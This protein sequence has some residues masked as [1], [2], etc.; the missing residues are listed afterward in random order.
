M[1]SKYK[2]KVQ[3]INLIQTLGYALSLSVF[4]HFSF[5]TN[6]TLEQCRVEFTIVDENREGIAGALVEIKEVNQ[7][8]IS[9]DGGRAI[10]L[11]DQNSTYTL[12]VHSLGFET[13]LKAIKIPG[14]KEFQLQV[15]LSESTTELSEVVVQGQTEEER[16]L[17]QPYKA[18]FISME[19][20]RS[21][22]VEVVNIINQMPGMRI[23][24]NGGA[25][26]DVDISINGI[27]GKGVKIFID[28]IPVYLLGA[29]YSFNN[30]S[31]GIIENIE[32][33]K[34]TIPV[35]FG[36]DALGGVINITTRQK[37]SDY[38]DVSYSYGSWNTHQSTLS[39][40]KR[41]G[42]DRK[43]S[44]GI[45]G[46]QTYS[47]NDYWMDDVLVWDESAT[48]QL[49]TTERGRARRFNDT[50]DSKLGR[51]NLGVR[52]LSWADEIVLF[53]SLSRVN[54]EWQHDIIPNNPWGEPSSEEDSWSSA[55]T[56]R[57]TSNDGRLS[58]NITGGYLEN[59][60]DFLDTARRTYYWDGNFIPKPAGA[61]ESGNY[62]N[63]TSPRTELNSFF[64]RSSLIYSIHPKHYVNLTTLFTQDRFK[65]T[66]SALPVERQE[67]LGEPQELLKNYIGLSVESSFMQDRIT[68][69]ISAKH[70]YQESDVVEFNA[71]ETGDLIENSSNSIGYGDVIRYRISQ[72]F[73]SNI[74]YEYTIRQPDQEE[75]FGGIAD[76]RIV[77]PNPYL[78]PELSN[79][80]NASLEWKNQQGNLRLVSGYFYRNTED[81]LFLRVVPRSGSQYINLTSTKTTGVE[82]SADYKKDNLKL[83]INGSYFSTKLKSISE[84]SDLSQSAIGLRIPN[85]PYLFANFTS[86]YSFTNLSFTKAEIALRYSVNYVNSFLISWDN[87]AT[88]QATTP[89]QT[90]HNLSAVWRA[91]KERWSLGLECRNL[92]DEQAFDNFNVQKPGRSFYIKARL[93]LD[94]L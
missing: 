47:D 48:P 85:E 19:D 87:N 66:N 1:R 28:E 57:N 49:P 88:G 24:Q 82:V 74:G 23:R 9:D 42:K 37:N 76:G 75:L 22:P 25:G 70:Y 79:N 73:T 44:I 33:Y 4:A 5:A 59:K 12:H 31:Q 21:Q 52:D 83:F 71:F 63:G 35:T 46:F 50:F 10:I 69:I 26:S 54:R 13:V 84:E 15:E 20:I 32:I 51:I 8:A 93:F 55:L 36:S 3:K 53:S 11:L 67:G 17:Q 77:I 16:V 27:G 91:P 60:L 62:D 78:E 41:F 18:E 81:K 90:I 64:V 86:D 40:N 92:L 89:T 94:K 39:A 68:N 58:L 80:F 6:S 30:L 29:G 45:E 56:W 43:F 7:K 61:G 2:G 72:N 34:G 14:R 65:I 38:L